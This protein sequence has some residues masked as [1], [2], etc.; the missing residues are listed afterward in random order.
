[1]LMDTSLKTDWITDI[2]SWFLVQQEYEVF[3]ERV[4]RVRGNETISVN[5]DHSAVVEVISFYSLKQESHP[6]FLCTC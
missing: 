5:G 1:M 6:F 4:M 3:L 2:M